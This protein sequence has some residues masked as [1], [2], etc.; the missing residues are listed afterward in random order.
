LAKDRLQQIVTVYAFSWVRMAPYG[1]APEGR[2]VHGGS[3]HVDTMVPVFLL[4]E[5]RKQ[6]GKVAEMHREDL[7]A[8][9]NYSSSEAAQRDP[10]PNHLTDIVRCPPMKPSTATAPPAFVSVRN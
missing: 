10:G 4:E 3:E 8:G 1:V 9:A 6:I 7:D 2:S 5:L